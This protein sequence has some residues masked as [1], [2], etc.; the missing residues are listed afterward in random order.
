MGGVLC[1]APE[2]GMG[3]VPDDPQARRVQCPREIGGCGVSVCGGGGGKEGG[4]RRRSAVREGCCGWGRERGRDAVGGGGREGGMLW[5]GEGEREGCCG[6][7]EGEREGC[8][9][10]GRGREGGMLWVGE[11]EREGCCGVGEGE[12]EGCCGGGGGR[13]GGML[14]GGGGRD[15]GVVCGEVCN[16]Y[17]H[18]ERCLL[19]TFFIHPFQFV[20][21]RLCKDT[22]H[23]GP[24]HRARTA[25][26]P[27][28]PGFQVHPLSTVPISTMYIV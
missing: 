24:C 11:G 5:V 20:F 7:G 18:R 4:K 2:C 1:P 9:G 16:I 25:E 17:I 21:C 12:R 28:Q 27:T 10:G 26:Q 19:K 13:E 15:A 8:C 6:V 22:F 23:N 3:L 14:W